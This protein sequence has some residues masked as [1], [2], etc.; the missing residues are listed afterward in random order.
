MST[1]PYRRR[2]KALHWSTGQR[3]QARSLAPNIPQ[4]GCFTKR[5]LGT[6]NRYD[7]PLKVQMFLHSLRYNAGK[8]DTVAS[9]RQVLRT[10][11]A[12]CLEGALTAAVILEQH[13]YPPLMLDMVSKSYPDHVVFLY[14]NRRTGL[15]GSIGKSG[16]PGL[17]GR[18]A[19]F[20]TVRGLLYSYFDPFIN[21][22]GKIIAYGVG[23]LYDLGDYD[24]RFSPNNMWRVERYFDDI[25]HKHIR[26]SSQRYR[27]WLNEYK[28]FISENPDRKPLFYKDRWKWHAGYRN[29]R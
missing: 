27:Y 13:G 17:C 7:T 9:F 16:D 5:E 18:K 11:K 3:N 4:S 23:N 24:W 21:L 10:S 6:I 20:K 14:R 25:R 15:W 12:D 28:I 22:S 1:A 8:P 29:M 19:V 2:L 26:S